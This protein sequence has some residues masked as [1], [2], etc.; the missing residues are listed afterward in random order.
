MW[1]SVLCES[2]EGGRQKDTLTGSRLL[3]NLGGFLLRLEKCLDSLGLLRGLERGTRQ[4][5]GVGK[6]GGLVRER[7]TCHVGRLIYVCNRMDP[8][9]ERVCVCVWVCEC[10]DGVGQGWDG[11]EAV[12]RV[13]G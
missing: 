5:V 1:P 2:K 11:G 6:T 3:H 10:G 13:V 7:W 4:S 9:R 8:E 12:Q